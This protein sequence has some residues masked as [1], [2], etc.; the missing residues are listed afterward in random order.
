MLCQSMM[1]DT[2][3]KYGHKVYTNLRD[4]NVSEDDKKCAKLLQS[5][6]L[7]LYLHT[8]ITITSKYI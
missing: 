6:L 3:R 4:I 2:A 8:K 7:T 1:T 5:F